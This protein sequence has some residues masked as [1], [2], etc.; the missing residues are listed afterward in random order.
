MNLKDKVKAKRDYRKYNGGARTGAGRKPKA[1]KLVTIRFSVFQSVVDKFGGI[2][3]VS[4][5]A[6]DWI[7]TISTDVFPTK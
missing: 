6:K 1:D 4:I 5:S 3:R 7:N 2:D